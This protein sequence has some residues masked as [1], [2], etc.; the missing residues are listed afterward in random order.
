[1]ISFSQVPISVFNLGKQT[2]SLQ[3]LY[4]FMLNFQVIFKKLQI[5]TTYIRE[6]S[7]HEWVMRGFSLTKLI[8]FIILPQ[9]FECV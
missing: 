7:R 1:M 2:T 9:R 8:L 4:E 3:I 5:Q 6:I